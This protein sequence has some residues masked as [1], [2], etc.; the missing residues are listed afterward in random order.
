MADNKR[1]FKVW[2]TILSDPCHANMSLEDVGRWVRLGALIVQSGENG[3]I[4]IS[5]PAN[6]FLALFN[7]PDFDALESALNVL[8]NVCVRREKSDNGKITVIM[9]NWIKY[10]CDSTVYERLK[11]YRKSHRDNGLRGEERRGEEKRVQ[12]LTN[13]PQNGPVKNGEIKY[14]VPPSPKP[15][16]EPPPN[17][18][19]LTP[20]QLVVTGFKIAMGIPDTDKTW[21]KV[22]FPRYT[23]SAKD[24]LTL[25]QGNIDKCADCIESISLAMSKKGLSWTPETIVKHASD[26]RE[27][28]LMK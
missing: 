12:N 16:P 21:D 22:Y 3:T 24:L 4:E 13:L 17:P 20:V 27:G 6:V 19:K 18:K 11:R 26:W 10:Q 23:R 28:R 1:W 7:V 15:S 14:P 25:F 2:G 9:E 5:P 8:P